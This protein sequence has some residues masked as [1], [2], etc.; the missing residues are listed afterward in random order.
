MMGSGR[1]APEPRGWGAQ[2]TGGAPAAAAPWGCEAM[3][4]F[5]PGTAPRS[6]PPR[7]FRPEAADH[8][9]RKQQRWR[10][11]GHSSLLPIQSRPT[12]SVARLDRGGYAGHNR[13]SP[14]ER[15]ARRPAVGGDPAH[16]GVQPCAAGCNPHP[17]ERSLR[18]N[19]V[20]RGRDAAERRGGRR[21][22]TGR[23]PRGGGRHQPCAAR[24]LPSA[25]CAGD[26][27]GGRLPN[28]SRPPTGVVGRPPCPSRAPRLL[29]APS[30]AATRSRR[31]GPI[32]RA[33]A[34]GWGGKGRRWRLRPPARPSLRASPTGAPLT[35]G[36]STA[37]CGCRPCRLRPLR[38]V[39][40]SHC[41]L[42]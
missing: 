31:R 16:G 6:P 30:P 28:R 21:K 11:R 17:L 8:R 41:P 10:R 2:P 13:H 20:H 4:L 14:T 39:L 25:T 23:P 26:P 24:P 19:P 38:A 1:A 34:S 3:R 42:V 12:P 9:A 5:R 35:G 27:H 40:Y 32:V 37:R 22:R 33:A 7:K 18:P 29:L 15:R 36:P